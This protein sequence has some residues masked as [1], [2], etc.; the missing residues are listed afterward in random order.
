MSALVKLLVTLCSFNFK[1]HTIH[2]FFLS[3]NK[4]QNDV[5]KYAGNF[6]KL[7]KYSMMFSEGCS[8]PQYSALTLLVIVQ[9]RGLKLAKQP[10]GLLIFQP[11]YHCKTR[12]RRPAAWFSSD[13]LVKWQHDNIEALP[14]VQGGVVVFYMVWP[15]EKQHIKP[16][17]LNK[18]FLQTCDFTK[19]KLKVVKFNLRCKK[20]FRM[21]K[22]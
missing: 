20:T 2:D 6:L 10:Q 17:I 4:K 18:R 19:Q 22:K 8:H 5:L 21:K 1:T 9:C 14:L 16:N 15:C 12:D 13:W 11:H 3:K 7:F